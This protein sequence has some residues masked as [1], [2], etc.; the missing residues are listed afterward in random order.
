M[1]LDLFQRLVVSPASVSVIRYTPLRTFVE[2]INDTGT[3]A[4]LGAPPV[5]PPSTPASTPPAT[6]P[7][8]EPAPHVS[9]DGSGAAPAAESIA[10]PGDPAN[11]ATDGVFGAAN[12]GMLGGDPGVRI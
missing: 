1:H 4:G 3:L 9:A 6:M 2:R 8:T 10:V 5:A 11:A 12:D 7:M